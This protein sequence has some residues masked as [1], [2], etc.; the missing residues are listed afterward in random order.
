[1]SGS[2]L[3]AITAS[4]R[5]KLE[6]RLPALC[7]NN[8]VTETLMDTMGDNGLTTVNLLKNTF[9]DESEW[10]TALKDAPFDLSGTDFATKLQIGKLV[11][12]YEACV[13]TA[14]VEALLRDLPAAEGAARF[15]VE[16][17]ALALQASLLLRFAPGEIA[18]T[19]CAT[20]LAGRG[21]GHY[22][23]LRD[24]RHARAIIER[25]MPAPRGLG[26]PS[27]GTQGAAP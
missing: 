2:G 8:G 25:A 3:P 21:A 13:A 14:E 23:A 26:R 22:G 16:R 18:E 10:R 20:R 17:M 27:A 12:V 15:V 4:G 7:H 24:T 5:D 6:V 19:F 1:M 11:V 9:A